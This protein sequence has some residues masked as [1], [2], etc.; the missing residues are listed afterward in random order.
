VKQPGGYRNPL[1]LLDEFCEQNT[2]KPDEAVSLINMARTIMT[3][4]PNILRI[5]APVK[6]VGDLH[7][8]FFDLVKIFDIAGPPGPDNSYLFLGDYVDRG[9]F[10]CEVSRLLFFS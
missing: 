3:N 4:E 7:G 1:W 5:Q 9:K 6:I 8:Q 2:I 10:S